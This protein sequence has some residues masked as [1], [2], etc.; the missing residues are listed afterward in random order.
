MSITFFRHAVISGVCKGRILPLYGIHFWSWN[1]SRSSAYLK[2]AWRVTYVRGIH[3][4]FWSVT[5]FRLK[6]HRRYFLDFLSGCYIDCM[7]RVICFWCLAMVIF[8]IKYCLPYAMRLINLSRFRILRDQSYV[9]WRCYMNKSR[10]LC[11]V[12]KQRLLKAAEVLFIK[13][14]L[15]IKVY[16]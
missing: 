14:N 9:R 10:L 16:S 1:T 3:Y 6:S 7:D 4:V 11:T 5:L 13:R 8:L 12:K 2:N 15:F